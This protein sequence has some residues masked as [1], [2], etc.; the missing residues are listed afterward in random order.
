M[1]LENS[2]ELFATGTCDIAAAAAKYSIAELWN[3]TVAG[4][5]TA[6]QLNLVGF[7]YFAD[8]ACNITMDDASTATDVNVAATGAPVWMDRR[9]TDS[10][11]ATLKKDTLGALI[12]GTNRGQITV[13]GAMLASVYIPFEHVLTPATGLLIQNNTQNV[14]LVVTPV[15]QEKAQI[16]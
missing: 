15:W 2:P 12:V 16:F 8:A 6:K 10:P 1:A 7:Y 4:A 11:L 5:A 13:G 14:R 9:R 3:A